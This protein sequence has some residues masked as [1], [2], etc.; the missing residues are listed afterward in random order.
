MDWMIAL[1]FVVGAT[2]TFQSVQ[3][4][5]ERKMVWVYVTAFF[6]A[7]NFACV[8]TRFGLEGGIV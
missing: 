7:A 6:A 1:N 3:A 4:F 2:L 5:R 8:W